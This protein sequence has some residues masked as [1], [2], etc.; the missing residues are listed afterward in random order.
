AAAVGRALAARGRSLVVL[1]NMEQIEGG[2]ALVLAWLDLA[3]EVRILS[4]SREP[5]YLIGEEIYELG[6]L[7]V[8][9]DMP[10][11]A[12]ALTLFVERVRALKRE[13]VPSRE[14][15]RAIV[16]VVR[17]VRGV[18]LAVELCASRFSFDHGGLSRRPPAMA[19]ADP[20]DPIAWSFGKLD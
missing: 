20:F 17:R 6:P 12:D 5:L 4:T 18:P 3:P 9:E 8:P 7:P 1:D 13:F 14:E 19:S 10:G 2:A 15:E 11:E 16:E